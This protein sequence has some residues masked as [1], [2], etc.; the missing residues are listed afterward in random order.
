MNLVT[1]SLGGVTVISPQVNNLDYVMVNQLNGWFQTEAPPN[2]PVV[3]DMGQVGYVDSAGFGGLMLCRRNIRSKGGDLLLCSLK[4]QVERAFR[5]MRLNLIFT[6]YSSRPEA[7]NAAR[8]MGD[9]KPD[10]PQQ[11]SGR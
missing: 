5:D 10:A 9:A 8:E 6:F 1:E 2:A 4:P 7:L 3:L 11:P